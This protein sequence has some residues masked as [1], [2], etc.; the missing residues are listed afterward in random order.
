METKIRVG[1]EAD[2]P[3][4]L[5]L[6]HELAVYEKEP[7]EVEVTEQQMLQWGFGKHP[8][9]NFF[10]AEQEGKVI[11]LALYYYKYSTWKGKCLFLEDIIVTEKY[12]NKN[13]GSMLFESVVKVAKQEG[14]KRLEWQVLEW[15]TPAI[16]FYKKYKANLDNTWL[17]GK[18]TYEQIQSL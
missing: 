13:I 2:I 18:L 8:L 12:R 1:L 5:Q 3:I 11:G 4:V 15:N 9:F 6:I 14:V 16:E 7:D 10:V 17:N